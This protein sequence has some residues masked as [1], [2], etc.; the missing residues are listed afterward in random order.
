MGREKGEAIPDYKYKFFWQLAS[1]L[2]EYS[3][4]I[5]LGSTATT[6]RVTNLPELTEP[7]QKVGTEG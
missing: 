2:T 4:P 7:C 1:T 3:I 6:A 5:T